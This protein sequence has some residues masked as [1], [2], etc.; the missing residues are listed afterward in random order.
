MN[1][2]DDVYHTPPYQDFSPICDECVE[3]LNNEEAF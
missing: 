2:N 1:S 3:K